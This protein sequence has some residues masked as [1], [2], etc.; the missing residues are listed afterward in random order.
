MQLAGGC[1]RGKAAVVDQADQIPHDGCVGASC[2]CDWQSVCATTALDLSLLLWTMILLHIYTGKHVSQQ[3][4][5]LVT[6]APVAGVAAF[7]VHGVF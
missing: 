6:A 7:A 3:A 4:L 1:C 2:V 5:G